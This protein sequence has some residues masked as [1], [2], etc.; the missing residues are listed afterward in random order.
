MAQCDSKT[1]AI[2]DTL[3]KVIAIPRKRGKF[4]SLKQSTYLKLI[5]RLTAETKSVWHILMSLLFA[6]G[7]IFC[8][9]LMVT[10]NAK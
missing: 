1:S 6:F 3:K 10:K 4:N 5:M 7:F 9:F 8:C 2:S